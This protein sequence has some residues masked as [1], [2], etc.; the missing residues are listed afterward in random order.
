M[1]PYQDPHLT[2]EQRTSDLLSRM[3]TREKVGQ[4]TQSLYGFH[5]Y[6]RKGDDVTLS[7]ELYREI[8]RYGGIGA[9]YGIFRA[10]P[11]SQK[12]FSTGA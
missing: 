10:D 9:I 7:D 12:D 4:L 8:E 2:V 1:Y 11:W 6:T 3:E 5:C